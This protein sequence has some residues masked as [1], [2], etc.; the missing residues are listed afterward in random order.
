MTDHQY[1]TWILE[2]ISTWRDEY[3]DI[4]D[5]HYFDKVLYWKINNAHTVVIPRDKEWF[6]N[7]FPVLQETWSKV[8]YYRENMEELP[9]V[10]DI[11]D[12][13][14]A[15][16]RYKTEFEV[17][18]FEPGS[19]FL[20]EGKA[21]SNNSAYNKP[22]TTGTKSNNFKNYKKTDYKQ[23]VKPD[24]NSCDFIDD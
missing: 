11:A 13:R 19:L 4:A 16:W 9:N 23:A 12:K 24:S 22:K 8:C 21:S 3:P 14:K 1:N 6:A 20:T 17:N 2:K 18:N 5:T 7:I 10:Q 15:F